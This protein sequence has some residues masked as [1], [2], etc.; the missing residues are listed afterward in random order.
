M[1]HTS[2][3]SAAPA[4]HVLVLALPEATLL[5]APSL[6]L[7]ETDSATPSLNRLLDDLMHRG[8]L[9]LGT[10]LQWQSAVQ[11]ALLQPAAHPQWEGQADPRETLPNALP[12]LLVDGVTWESHLMVLTARC[13]RIECWPL[14]QASGQ[15][16]SHTSL[17]YPVQFLHELNVALEQ[18]Q[19]DA[20]LEAMRRY[21]GFEQV[22]LHG[23]GVDASTRAWKRAL[24]GQA[25]QIID[26][27]TPAATPRRAS[28]RPV[29]S[30]FMD[31]FTLESVLE[32]CLTQNATPE[33]A[34]LLRTLGLRSA[35]VWPLLQGQGAWGVLAGY[36]RQPHALTARQ[37]ET[38]Q[39][40]VTL[41]R[42][43][44]LRYRT[45]LSASQ[46]LAQHRRLSGYLQ[47]MHH[48]LLTVALADGA[49]YRLD[50]LEPHLRA[51]LGDCSLI[52]WA[53]GQPCAHT[54]QEQPPEWQGHWTHELCMWIT[55]GLQQEPG[56]RLLLDDRSA[57]QNVPAAWHGTGQCMAALAMPGHNDAWIAVWRRGAG[58][59]SE[60]EMALLQ[61]LVRHVATHYQNWV[62]HRL[63]G[64]LRR[65][66]EHYEQSLDRE[67][68]SIALMVHDELCQSL[69]ATRISAS[70]LG[71]RL[72]RWMAALSPQDAHAVD[73]QTPTPLALCE[74]VTDMLDEAIRD[75]RQL[76]QRLHPAILRRGL[77][78]GLEWLAQ[79]FHKRWGLPVQ[80]QLE[81]PADSPPPGNAAQL[82]CFCVARE[83]LQNI[84]KHAQAQQVWLRL[85]VQEQGGVR[86]LV[87]QVEDN[88]CG[89]DTS[90]TDTEPSAAG[91]H[92]GVFG[93]HERAAWIGAEL[94]LRSSPGQGTCVTLTL[95]A[96]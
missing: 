44:L 79:D 95:P 4:A 62:L 46:T 27:R 90:A 52:A 34:T 87:L 40:A 85:A 17:P 55:R 74:Q 80:V 1:S 73:S 26:V 8:L 16:G 15:A 3:P 83:A 49:P 84:Q 91:E 51:A 23:A 81:L 33:E 36:H 18:D 12:P 13:A 30:T 35:W 88:G 47:A 24:S 66:S 86:Q 39:L 71:T 21:G 82:V 58:V 69:A 60:P 2:P 61:E 20:A 9:E 54:V 37:V 94:S 42:Q 64:Q 70:L 63:R 67:R 53:D 96:A 38:L 11:Q 41:V 31:Q 29:R 76:I 19:L 68:A 93:M 92:F 22:Q 45:G 65:F 48:Q 75:S 7:Q 5:A 56:R 57:R 78:A 50:A 28:A 10:R 72:G 59:W 43:H 89:F 32:G 25:R 77:P 6:W 14:I